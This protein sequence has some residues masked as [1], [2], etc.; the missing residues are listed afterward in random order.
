MTKETTS[1]NS[2]NQATLAFWSAKSLIFQFL[3]I[4]LAISLPVI[5]H[6]AQAPVRFLLPMHWPVLL[7][8]LVYG[9]RGG[10][11]VGIAAP[12]LSY[13]ISGY[14]LPPILPAMTVEL[15]A[16]GFIVGVLKERFNL[17]GFLA[18]AIAL[19][20]GR[21]SFLLVAGITGGAIINQAY[22][23]AAMLP[24]LAAAICQLILLPFAAKWWIE[25]IR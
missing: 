7:A 5:A 19:I 21:I 12:V 13:A 10:A 22:L 2:I 9:W 23:V 15:F 4:T 20:A 1:D 18:M 11:L 8:G 14:P 6:L 3:L 16:Y 25:R 17:G 24:G